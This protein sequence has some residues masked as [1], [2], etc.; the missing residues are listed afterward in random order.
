MI[1]SVAYSTAFLLGA[2]H[3]LEPGHGKSFFAAY[4][5][6][7]KFKWKNILAMGASLLFSHFFVLSLLALIL[8]VFFNNVESETLFAVVKWVAPLIVIAF[9]IGLWIRYKSVDVDCS[10]NNP[11]HHHH[12]EMKNN[13]KQASLFGLI[14]G[15]LPCPT[16]IT[17][18]LL[19]GATSQFTDALLII[20]I[21]V[22]GM[23]LVLAGIVLLLMF[24]K[25]S[26][27]KFLDRFE[28][29]L[30]P[31]LISAGLVIFVGFV[32]LTY[33]FFGH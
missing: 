31:Q 4:L 32:Y 15:L 10:C 19:S 7:E 29:K 28:T 6:G 9:G 24:T 5:V 2:L 18:L 33:N 17:A 30:N 25:D 13:I 11:H 1:N 21:Y 26:I 14:G 22:L 23:S 3:A 8:N 12:P 16:A 27:L 20:A